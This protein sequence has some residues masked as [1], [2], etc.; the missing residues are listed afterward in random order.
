MPLTEENAKPLIPR[1]IKKEEES[2]KT[3]EIIVTRSFFYERERQLVDKK[4]I[5]PELFAIEMVAAKKAKFA[6]EVMIRA[7][8]EQE[9][10]DKTASRTK[11][12]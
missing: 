10:F 4:L 6:P 12:E 2:M 7:E 8:P 11:K 1:L 9:K 5:V 3:R